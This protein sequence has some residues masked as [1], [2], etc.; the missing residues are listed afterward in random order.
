MA[1]LHN[2]PSD[3]LGLIKI[4]MLSQNP[5]DKMNKKLLE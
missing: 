4:S 2:I 3:I 1:F 5:K